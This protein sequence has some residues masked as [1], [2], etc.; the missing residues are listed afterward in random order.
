MNRA[1]VWRSVVLVGV[2]LFAALGLVSGQGKPPAD[3][4][5]QQQIAAGRRIFSGS[6]GMAYCHGLDGAGGAG[7]RLRDRE[8]TAA[9]LM[10]LISEGVPGTSMPAFGRALKR[11]EL[12]QLVAFLL[13]VNRERAEGAKQEDQARETAAGRLD[14]HLAGQPAPAVTPA[15]AGG[16]SLAV[17]AR[18]PDQ[19][20]LTSSIAGN[21]Q[22]GREIF[23]DPANLSSCRVCHT[24]HG[25]GG[26]VAAD[27]SRLSGAAPSEIMRRLLAP[28]TSDD[29]KHPLVSLTLKSGERMTGIL[30]DESASGVRLFDTEVLPPVSRHYL[31][32]EIA[33]L[34]RLDRTGCP[35]GHAARFTLQQ[36]LDLI[37]LIRTP[38]PAS[39]ARV[40]ADELF[41]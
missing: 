21:W 11:E 34:D 10:K 8:Y 40:T 35:G 19:H 39:P 18:A 41:R 28:R 17:A 16:A 3:P 9:G 25:R 22:A 24:L 13:S 27:L 5:R 15:T 29:G 36:L 23:F 38:D 37:A 32:T 12:A 1:R 7:P 30:R 31:R 4:A 33:A 20:P 6:C 2:A 26:R 14:P